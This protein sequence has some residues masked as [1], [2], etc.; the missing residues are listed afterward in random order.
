[1]RAFIFRDPHRVD[2]VSLC[3]IQA[4]SIKT[5][6]LERL[7]E[8]GLTF[9]RCFVVTL[10]VCRSRCKVP[11]NH[12]DRREPNTTTASRTAASCHRSDMA[13]LVTDAQSMIA[14]MAPQRQPGRFRFQTIASSEKIPPNALG[15]FR[16][17]E[18]LSVIVPTTEMSD[19][20]A[21]AWI[22]LTVHSS[23]DGVGLT[24]AVSQALAEQGIPC[25]VVAAAHH[26]HLFVPESRADETVLILESLAKRA[27]TE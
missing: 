25:N 15:T 5:F 3:G 6:P 11:R 8:N 24:A 1:M 17:A 19:G 23:L 20:S 26:D 27:S 12:R 7:T 4:I 14:G 16:E 10:E 21:F 22:T 9:F 2:A 13:P 18:G